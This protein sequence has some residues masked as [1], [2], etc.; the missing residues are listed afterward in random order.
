MVC[1]NA[2]PTHSY[3]VGLNSVAGYSLA[4]ASVGVRTSSTTRSVT[5]ESPDCVRS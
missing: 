1:S 5:G 4:D 2:Q 3:V